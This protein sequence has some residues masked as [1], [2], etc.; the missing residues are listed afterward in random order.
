MGRVCFLPKKSIAG[1]FPHYSFS[2]LSL[3]IFQELF[4]FSGNSFEWKNCRLFFGGV[5]SKAA[6]IKRKNSFA[7][8]ALLYEYKFSITDFFFLY[9]LTKHVYVEKLCLSA[10]RLSQL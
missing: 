5:Q 6:N 4:F 9:M 3:N 10:Q 7:F 1:N 8:S 2:V